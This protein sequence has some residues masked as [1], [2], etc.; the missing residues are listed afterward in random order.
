MKIKR[1]EIQDIVLVCPYCMNE[2]S[3]EAGGCC[4]EASTHFCKAVDTEDER[5][6]LDDVQI[7]EDEEQV[8][9]P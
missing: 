5:Y 7:I 3:D 4:G 8:V 2:K 9:R 6:L 1:S